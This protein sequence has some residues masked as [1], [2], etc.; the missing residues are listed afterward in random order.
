MDAVMVGSVMSASLLGSLH[1]VGMCGGLVTLYAGQEQRGPEWTAHLAYNLG[2]LSIYTVLGALAGML[3]AGLNLAGELLSFQAV[4][5]RLAGAWMVLWGL[6]TLV[7]ALPVLQKRVG[8]FPNPLRRLSARVMPLYARL[9]TRPGVGAA[10]S[11]GLLSAALPC[12]W[13]YLF[14]GAAAGAGSAGAGASMMALFWLGTLPAMATLGMVVKRLSGRLRA[15]LPLVAALLLVC[16]GLYTVTGK[17]ET[18]GASAA[19]FQQGAE[20]QASGV[21]EGSFSD[22]A[23]H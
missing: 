11:V 18:L 6:H 15:Q 5:A 21:V 19:S 3:G 1:C 16:A 7:Q 10:L 20:G 14:V 22:H 9:R 23:C 4:A 2:R 8:T 13:L 17:L 12:G